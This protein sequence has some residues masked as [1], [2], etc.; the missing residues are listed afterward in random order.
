MERVGDFEVGQDLEFQRRTWVVQ[1]AG[2][3]GMLLVVLVALLGYFGHGPLTGGTAGSA[4]GGLELEYARFARHRA[5]TQLTFTVH[6]D[7]VQGQQATIAIAADYLNGL[8]IVGTLPEP[9]SVSVDP[10]WVTYTFQVD[11]VARPVRITFDVQPIEIGLRTL[12]ARAGEGEPIRARQ[13]VY[14]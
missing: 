11:D 13:L 5:D 3:A 8:E 9:D 4:A 12:R 6:P 7:A 14:P 10:D 1:R 2:W